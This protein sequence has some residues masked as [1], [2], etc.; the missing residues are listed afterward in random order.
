MQ[1]VL[2][3]PQARRME[4]LQ[5][6]ARGR[7]YMMRSEKRPGHGPSAGNAGGKRPPKRRRRRAGFF[8]KLVTMLLLLIIWPLGLLLLW[9]RRL[10]WGALTKLLTSIVTLAASIIL[11]G[12]AL[13]V[14]TGNPAYTAAQDRI[15]GYLDVAADWVVN[16]A[17]V[18]ADR[19]ELVYEGAQDLGAALWEKAKP[20]IANTIDSGLILAHK[21]RTQFESLT[22]RFRSDE[23]APD[24]SASSS[25]GVAAGST[26]L[27]NT[28]ATAAATP[29]ATPRPTVEVYVNAGD[30][31]LPIYIPEDVPQAD[32]GETIAAGMLMRSGA[33]DAGALPTARPTPEPTPENTVFEVKPAAEA[34]VYYNEGS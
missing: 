4:L 15:N 16:A 3:T 27:S 17:D 34:I 30:A 29:S 19:A 5:A 8:Y 21:A 1:A 26:P 28:T 7:D 32:E 14:N 22:E 23:V 31:S 6:F 20:E 25:P 2:S 13:T 12:F 11:I 10:R 18:A 33:L 9:R 24:P